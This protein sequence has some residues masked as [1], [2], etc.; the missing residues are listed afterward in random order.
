LKPSV[1]YGEPEQ[2]RPYLKLNGPMMGEDGFDDKKNSAPLV[3]KHQ[4][5]HEGEYEIVF[6]QCINDKCVPSP[7]DD[8]QTV[9]FPLFKFL[10]PS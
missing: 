1:I 2:E 6:K 3:L 7:L 8:R 4:T 5:E 10:R 9:L